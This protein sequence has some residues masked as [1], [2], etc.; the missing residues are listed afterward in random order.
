MPSNPY[1]SGDIELIRK[2]RERCRRKYLRYHDRY[3]KKVKERWEA[4]KDRVVR[5]D[6]TIEYTKARVRLRRMCRPDKAEAVRIRRTF[7]SPDFQVEVPAEM[8]RA[9]EIVYRDNLRQ[10]R[11]V[12]GRDPETGR[13]QLPASLRRKEVSERAKEA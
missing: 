11:I 4:R 13:S 1:L 12:F 3:L 7:C 8:K 5:S 2:E 10:L 6:N 9:A